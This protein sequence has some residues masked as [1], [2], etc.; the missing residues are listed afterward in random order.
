MVQGD[1]FP[2]RLEIWRSVAPFIVAA[3]PKPHSTL[4]DAITTHHFD[5]PSPL[6]SLGNLAL[7]DSSLDVLRALRGRRCPQNSVK[8]YTFATGRKK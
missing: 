6:L 7:A 2:E 3:I 4:A 1:S 5:F 8:V